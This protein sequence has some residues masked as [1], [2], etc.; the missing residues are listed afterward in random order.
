MFELYSIET[1][2]LK[3]KGGIPISQASKIN[4]PG[5]IS[6]FTNALKKLILRMLFSAH[7]ESASK[8]SPKGIAIF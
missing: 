5:V 6:G 2:T 4:D 8:V 3:H 7:Q 1:G